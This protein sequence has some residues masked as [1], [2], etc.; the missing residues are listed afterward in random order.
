MTRARLVIVVCIAI[1]NIWSISSLYSSLHQAGELTN[2][3]ILYRQIAW[4]TIGWVVLAIS[5]FINYRL[6]FDL[7][8]FL[9]IVDLALLIG[10]KFLGKEVMGARRWF[11]FLGMNFQPSE[12]SKVVTVFILARFFSQSFDKNIFVKKVLLPLG[13]VL[14]SSFLIFKQPDLGTALICIFVFFLMGLSSSIK[15]KYFVF[16]LITGILITPLGW[17]FLK[18]YQKKRL[19]VF[20]NPNCEPLGAGYTILQSKIAIGSGKILGKGFLSGTQNQFNFLPERHTDFIFT[21]V[22]EEWGFLGSL[23]LLI[24]Y[25]LI[26]KNILAI[27]KEAK[28]DFARYILIGTA[29]L[30]FLHIFINIG[31]T[32]GMLPVVGL[33]LIFL[34]YGGTHLFFN[35]FLLGVVFNISRQ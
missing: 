12:F 16:C 18:D 6:Y 8:L 1:L 7:S 30:F 29:Y 17:R 28:D 19:L 25:Y 27:T 10:V 32:L 34:S 15:K 14:L 2:E 26:L 33:P 20:L 22:A 35:F 23:F 5:S 4:I 11:S 24:I 13:L 21:V 31:M 3:Y 9:Y